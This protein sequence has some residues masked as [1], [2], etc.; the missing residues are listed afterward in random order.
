MLT[1][2]QS[3]VVNQLAALSGCLQYDDKEE[4]LEHYTNG[5]QTHCPTGG[6]NSFGVDEETGIA[7]DH[8]I[9][10]VAKSECVY[11]VHH[12]AT[13]HANRTSL[14]QIWDT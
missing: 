8:W 3:S 1:V 9:F 2:G 5:T 12:T 13:K 7:R 14:F 11:S 4:E 6:K 10:E